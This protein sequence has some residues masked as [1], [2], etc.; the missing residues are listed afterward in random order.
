MARPENNQTGV[1]TLNYV[2]GKTYAVSLP[3]EIIR[4]LKWEKGNR[5]MVRRQGDK[6]II[7]KIIED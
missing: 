7:E 3:I 2:G 1:R 4:L 6:V 5:L